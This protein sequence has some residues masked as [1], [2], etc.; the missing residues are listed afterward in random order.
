MIEVLQL[1]E[2]DEWRDR[3]KAFYSWHRKSE[4]KSQKQPWTW[5]GKDSQKWSRVVMAD[6]CDK[7]C[8]SKKLKSPKSSPKLGF[9]PTS[10]VAKI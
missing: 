1:R 4:S 7:A 5:E 8:F 9:D 3:V 6:V 2:T 10:K